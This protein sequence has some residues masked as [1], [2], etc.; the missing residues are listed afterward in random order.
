M[1]DDGGEEAAAGDA[2]GV[3]ESLAY[4][5]R[6]QGRRRVHDAEADSFMARIAGRAASRAFA[7]LWVRRDAEASAPGPQHDA[8]H[9]GAPAAEGLSAAMGHAALDAVQLLAEM[10]EAGRHPQEVAAYADRIAVGWYLDAAGSPR[11]S[12]W[13]SWCRNCGGGAGGQLALRP[14]LG[15]VAPGRTPRSGRGGGALG[16]SARP[17][18]PGTASLRLI[19]AA[20]CGTAP[21]CQP[22]ASVP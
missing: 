6:Y 17:G 20:L 12:G 2:R 5:L 1:P 18:A 14:A 21:T 13:R 7:A 4:A 11:R 10:A 16:G 15:S 19:P 3:M 8:A 22:S 9:A